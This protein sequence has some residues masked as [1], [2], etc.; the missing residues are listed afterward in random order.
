[1][2]LLRLS[3]FLSQDKIWVT[4]QGPCTLM[5]PI[6]FSTQAIFTIEM[7]SQDSAWCYGSYHEGTE[8]I[9]E[10]WEMGRKSSIIQM[11]IPCLHLVM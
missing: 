8:T 5:T 6:D 11:L 9:R 1:M 3:A 2:V 4:W 7:S 10:L